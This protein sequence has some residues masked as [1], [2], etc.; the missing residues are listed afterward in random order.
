MFELKKGIDILNNI[1]G[2]KNAEE[3]EKVFRGFNG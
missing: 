3:V 1:G 2:V